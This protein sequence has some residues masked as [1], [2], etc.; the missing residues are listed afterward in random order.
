MMCISCT[1][2]TLKGV[3]SLHKHDNW[4]SFCILVLNWGL[5]PSPQMAPGLC[6]STPLHDCH[7]KTSVFP[8]PYYCIS[9]SASYTTETHKAKKASATP[10]QVILKKWTLSLC[11]A[12][13]RQWSAHDCVFEWQVITWS[14]CFM[15]TALSAAAH[16]TWTCLI[17]LLCSLL[18]VCRNALF[19]ESQRRSKVIFYWDYLQLYLSNADVDWFILKLNATSCSK[20]W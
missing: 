8:L 20:F 16:S 15:P 19:L 11:S 5:C 18:D 13:A 2:I 1:W 14:T 17:H 6:P 10:V 3:Y 9:K 4:Q 7:S 12:T